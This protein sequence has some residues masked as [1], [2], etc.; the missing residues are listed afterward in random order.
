M[1]TS[2]PI[3]WRLREQRYRLIGKICPECYQVS[4]PPREV[5]PRC[6]QQPD[7]FFLFDPTKEVVAE[8]LMVVD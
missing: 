1:T 8:A 6:S 7:P 4:F 5:C 3:P 2:V